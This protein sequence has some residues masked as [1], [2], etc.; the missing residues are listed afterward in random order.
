MTVS[1][2]QGDGVRSVATAPA[3]GPLPS[4]PTRR[5]VV[6]ALAAGLFAVV[7]SDVAFREPGSL[8][9]RI[10]A[11]VR[12]GA[13]W[14][15]QSTTIRPAARFVSRVTGRWLAGV[16]TVAVLALALAG[17]RRE[18]V[19]VAAGTLGAWLLSMQ[20]AVWLVPRPRGRPPWEAFVDYGFPSGHTLVSFVAFGLLAWSVGRRAGA[21]VR[22]GLWAGAVGGAAVSG[23]AR[24][25]LDAHWLSD[26]I[27]GL[28]FGTVW[29]L[30]VVTVAEVLEARRLHPRVRRDLP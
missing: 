27:G 15:A 20:K 13:G 7:A 22:A 5:L 1:V 3:G 17:W 26:V 21:A 28:L 18:A 16:V 19:A 23:M 25:V 14:A 8:L 6:G 10:D 30:L 12:T 24:I 11:R 29:I 9:R 4:R 2:D